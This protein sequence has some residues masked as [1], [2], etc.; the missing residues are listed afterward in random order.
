MCSSLDFFLLGLGRRGRW[1]RLP[2]YH[3]RSVHVSADQHESVV[4]EPVHPPHSH[5]SVAVGQGNDA[6]LVHILAQHHHCFN[7]SLFRNG[8]LVGGGVLD[9][10]VGLSGYKHGAQGI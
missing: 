5:H 10:C 4:A 8:L 3:E 7:L 2:G 6:V 9:G 1:S